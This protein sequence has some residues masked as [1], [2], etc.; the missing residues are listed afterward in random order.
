MNPLKF[1]PVAQAMA[2]LSKDPRTK[3]GAVVIDSDGN[4]LVTG[5]NGFPRGVGDNPDR[6]ADRACK[7]RLISHAEANCIAQAARN[8]IRLKGASIVLTELFPC[9]NCAKLI[10]QAGIT[11]VYAP[12]M[13]PGHSIE[14]YTEKNTSDLLFDEAEVEVI[15]YAAPL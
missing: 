5:Y 6:Y 2:G 11:R 8:G 7:L 4:I 10:I 15:E 1:I 9:S 13:N 14:W 12:V 3:V